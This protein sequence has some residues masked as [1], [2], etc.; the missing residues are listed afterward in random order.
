MKSSEIRCIKKNLDGSII[1][2]VAENIPRYESNGIVASLISITKKR[3]DGDDISK[4]LAKFENKHMPYREAL[5][6]LCITAWDILTLDEYFTRKCNRKYSERFEDLNTAFQ[7]FKML[8]VVETREVSTMDDVIRHF[9][10]IISRNGEGI[11]VKSKDGVWADTKPSYQIKIKKEV[12]LDLK[13]TGFNYGT[14][15]NS[16]LISSIDVESEDG[17]LKT[18]PTGIN[19]EDMEYITTNQDK[20]LGKIVEIKCSGISQDS[21]GNYSVLHPVYK[22][23]RD[24]KNIANTLAECIEINE[25]SS[26]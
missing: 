12:N 9:E 17:L 21:R 23:F 18:S 5:D 22:H 20:L 26:I 14:G 8:S 13:A 2:T 16:N 3:A 15:K 1:L 10:E 4:E 7:G 19:E 25:S 6:R 24:D 11:V